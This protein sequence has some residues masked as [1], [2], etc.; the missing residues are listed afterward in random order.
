M[1]SIPDRKRLDRTWLLLMALTVASLIAGRADG[2]AAPGLMGA[3]VVLVVAVVK[4]RGILM[5]FLNLRAAPAGWRA[6]FIVWLG[7]VAAT[8]WLTAAL[9][10]L[11]AH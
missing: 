4:A 5:E 9:P 7:A 11:L 1:T 2:S 6:V 3:A 8:L 10:A